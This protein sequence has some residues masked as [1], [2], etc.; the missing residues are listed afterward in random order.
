MVLSILYDGDIDLIVGH[1]HGTLAY[2]ENNT[3]SSKVKIKERSITDKHAVTLTIIDT[4]G[5]DTLDLR[6]D[7][8]DQ[9]IDLRPE[10][11]SDVYGKTGNLVIAR[12]TMIGQVIAGKGNDFIR[13]NDG[14]NRLV[15]WTGDDVMMGGAGNDRFAFYP[16]DG[17]DMILDF[18]QGEDKID[19]RFLPAITS[20][21]D[22]SRKDTDEGLVIYL[23]DDQS[24][25]VTLIGLERTDMAAGDFLFG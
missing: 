16:N 1:T 24:D 20:I 25:S 2:F 6:T 10:G 13:G 15:G 18:T 14:P 12:D 21:E 4:D 11:I 5:Y 22:L 17:H 8:H 19:L 23:T 9:R 3:L 7:T